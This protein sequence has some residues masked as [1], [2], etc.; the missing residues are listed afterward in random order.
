MIFSQFLSLCAQDTATPPEELTPELQVLFHS[1]QGNWESAHD[2]AQDLPG[3]NGA[4]LHAFLHREEGDLWNADYWYQNAGKTTPNE[5]FSLEKEWKS[6]AQ[7]FCK[8]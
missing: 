6:L 1:K 5:D 4:W 2:I 7:H 3:T 8:S